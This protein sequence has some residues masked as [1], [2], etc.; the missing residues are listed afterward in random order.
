[1]TIDAF[2]RALHH[3]PLSQ[4]ERDELTPDELFVLVLARRL[5]RLTDAERRKLKPA[6]QKDWAAMG[7]IVSEAVE[8]EWTMS[9]LPSPPC[10]GRLSDGRGP[11]SEVHPPVN[12]SAK[13]STPPII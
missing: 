2:R 11:A 3:Q 12:S 9:I 1:M 4:H 10:G 7:L 13:S 5:D 8:P 6:D